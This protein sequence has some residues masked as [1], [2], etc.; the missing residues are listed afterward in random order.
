MFI[1]AVLLQDLSTMPFYAVA[2]WLQYDGR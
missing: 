2:E 1:I